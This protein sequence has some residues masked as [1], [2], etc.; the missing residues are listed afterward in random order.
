MSP[1]ATIPAAEAETRALEAADDLF[2]ARGIGSV[3][4][5]EIRDRSGLSLRRLYATHP[6][7]ADLVAAWLRHR[8]ETWMAGFRAD[9]RV[10]LDAGAAPVDAV[11]DALASWMEAT[12]WR[13]CGFINTH[14]LG[15]DL[16]D[17]HRRI[18]RDHKAALA[19][20]LDALTPK[21]RALAVVVDGA[22]VQASIFG[23]RHPIDLA[24]TAGHAL[25]TSAGNEEAEQ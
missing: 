8:H 25:V 1:A 18:I 14:A 21:G 19:D 9:L 11:F 5:G 10:A 17:E 24:R 2:Y 13:G 15:H 4:M 12:G 7:K 22:I 3:T 23:N 20:E 6:S 16:T